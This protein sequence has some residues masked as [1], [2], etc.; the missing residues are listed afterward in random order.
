ML[1]EGDHVL[2]SPLAGSGARRKIKN[3]KPKGR[4]LRPIIPQLQAA[5]IKNP[6]TK[7]GKFI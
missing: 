1:T 2:A 4:A 7:N 3:R 5:G 6:G